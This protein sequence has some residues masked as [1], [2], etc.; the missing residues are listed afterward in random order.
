MLRA[1]CLWDVRGG[2]A[3]GAG[4]ALFTAPSAEERRGGAER[5]QQTPLP[6]PSSTATG[7]AGLG[8]PAPREARLPAAL[9]CQQL[10]QALAEG[11]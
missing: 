8:F 2:C 5:R 3:H 11:L 9:T 6:P 10:L 1:L 7:G 4:S